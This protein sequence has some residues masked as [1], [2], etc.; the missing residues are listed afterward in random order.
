[1][2]TTSGWRW[3]S[4]M[5]AGAL[6]LSGCC[7]SKIAE[8]NKFIGVINKNSETI[9]KGAE[10]LNSSKR[11]GADI[12]EFAKAIDQAGDEIKAVELKDDAL[13]KF[14]KDYHDMLERYAAAAKNM[15]ST[16]S[17][18]QSKA[19]AELTGIDATEAALVNKI[20]GYCG[21]K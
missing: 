4:A 14:A 11:T 10:K 3:G 21:G 16:D 19:L 2:K 7:G 5:L 12:V 20:N 18:V 1:M 15:N 17:A 13:S 8:C 6:L 9:K